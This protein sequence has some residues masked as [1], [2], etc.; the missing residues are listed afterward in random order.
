MPRIFDPKDLPYETVTIKAAHSDL[1]VC[2]QFSGQFGIWHS[3]GNTSYLSDA[4]VDD[5]ITALQFYKQ[6]KINNNTWGKD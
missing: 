1:V 5:L 3:S 2:P 6:H 4:A